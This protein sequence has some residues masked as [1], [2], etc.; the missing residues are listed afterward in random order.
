MS[1]NFYA[2]LE[3]EDNPRTASGGGALAAAARH[4]M[5]RSR[6][7]VERLQQLLAIKW[8]GYMY[9]NGGVLT[10]CKILLD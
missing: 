5:G 6:Q 2:G 10:A 1:M 9:V 8:V 7:Q 3:R 4:Q